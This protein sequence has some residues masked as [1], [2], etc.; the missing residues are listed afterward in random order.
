MRRLPPLLA[1]ALSGFASDL[2]PLPRLPVLKPQPVRIFR[3]AVPRQPWTVAGEHGAIFGRQDGSFEA[4]IWPNKILSHFQIS[5]E[6][7]DYDV[8]IDVND[9]AATIAVTPAETVI[10][11]SHAAFSIRQHAF[12]P[13]GT[14][15]PVTGAVVYFEIESVRPITLTFSFTPEMLPMWPAPEYGRPDGEWVKTGQS[16]IY[17]L[18][19]GN[20]EFSG[21]VGMPGTQP[22]ILAPYQE[23]PH[24]YPLQLKLT[25]D[26]KVNKE[27]IYPLIMGVSNGSEATSQA[28]K[29]NEA[30]AELH[31]ATDSY[32]D[33]F[34]DSRTTVETP[35][36]RLDDAIRWAEISIDQMQVKY[37]GETGMVA[38][39]YESADSARPGY[40]WFF[41]RDTLWTTYAVNS[42]GDF[43]LTRTALD[44]LI[45]RQRADGKIMHEFSQSADAIDWSKTP[46]FYASADSTPL[47]VMAMWDYVRASGD[48]DYLKQNWEAVQK[49]F[50]FER[51][52]DSD[53][54]GIYENTEG[55]GWVESWPPGMPHQE[56]YLAALDQQSCTAMSHLAALMN[57]QPLAKRASE[58]AGKIGQTIESE[59]YSSEDQFYAF[60]RN[61]DGTLDHTPSIFPS[62]AW[63]QGTY[64]LQK[65]EPM[66]ARWAAPEFSTDWG[67]RD[68]SG[69]SQYFDP[70]SYHQGSVW[71]LF[72]GWVSLAEY[73]AGMTL[74]GYEHL[75]ENLR[76]TWLQD[77]GAAT[78]LL[79]GEFYEPLGRSS[80]HQMWSSAMILAPAMR[81]LFGLQA[82][83]VNNALIV[84]PHLPAQWDHARVRNVRV[85]EQVVDLRFQRAAEHLQITATTAVAGVLCLSDGHSRLAPCA[86][87]ASTTHTLNLPL[88][89][90]ELQLGDDGPAEGDRTHGIKVLGQN[91]TDRGASFTLS[92]PAGTR[93]SVFVRRNNPRVHANEFTMKG[94]QL[95][96]KFP[97]GSGYQAVTVTFGW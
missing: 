4:W 20:P 7:Q 60:S 70:I 87:T 38:G 23:R 58:T 6:L 2:K 83:A 91:V 31:R 57:D 44:F 54:D 18:H 52:H 74:A 17:I 89:A 25:Y 90:V 35:D 10:T 40:A 75:Y 48:V 30:I 97:E 45:K 65:A 67:T 66:L 11:Y 61:A 77:L 85:G 71:P 8:P 16:G 88:P 95:E 64:G 72:T 55:T 42:Y 14:P 59:Y 29:V 68:I 39:Y 46:Y 51:S 5:A 96:V 50:Q 84:D 32:Y 94:D 33:H 47:L 15:D 53:K 34:F 13:R 41:G 69:K 73:R 86:Q 81:G 78:E 56:I 22:G 24:M 12:A 21:I 27:Q 49:A 76:L 9:L 26:P 80:S 37:G 19:T 93:T 28:Q 36:S 79:S 62:V 92:A 1:I 3:E 43:A 82:D 63:W